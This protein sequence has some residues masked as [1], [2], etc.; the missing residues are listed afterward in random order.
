MALKFRIQ[1][2]EILGLQNYFKV[3]TDRVEIK[4]GEYQELIEQKFKRV[5]ETSVCKDVASQ[6]LKKAPGAMKELFQSHYM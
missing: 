5:Y 4:K 1:Q 6:I 3:H 2:N